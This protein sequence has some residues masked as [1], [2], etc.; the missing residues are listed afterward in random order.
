MNLD[1]GAKILQCLTRADYMMDASL[2]LATIVNYNDILYQENK[3]DLIRIYKMKMIT[4]SVLHYKSLCFSNNRDMSAKHGRGRGGG[5]KS[6]C[7]SYILP[8]LILTTGRA[9]STNCFQ[10]EDLY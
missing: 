3:K 9:F 2:C 8:F 5:D 7:F 1:V 4:R 10:S 6:E